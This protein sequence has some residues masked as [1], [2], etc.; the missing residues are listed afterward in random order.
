MS[1]GVL[2]AVMIVAQK[3]HILVYGYY[4]TLI[5]NPMMEPNALV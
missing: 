4:R 3:R 2:T 1:M 5:A